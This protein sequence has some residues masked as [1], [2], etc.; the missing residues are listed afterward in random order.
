MVRILLFASLLFPFAGFGQSYELSSLN[1]DTKTSIRGLSIISDSVAWASGSNGHIGKTID[2]GQNW[3]WMQPLGY[4]KLDFRDIEAFDADRA[5]IVNAGSPAYILKTE[6]GGKSW[7]EVYKNIDSA[8]FLDGMDFWSEKRGIAFGDPIQNHLQLL[9]TNDGG[10][11]WTDIS[12]KL[13]FDM[14]KGEAGFAAS[15]TTIKALPG[16]RVWIATGGVKSNIYTSEDYG[17]NW[18]KFECPILQGSASTGVFGM[19]FYEGSYGSQGIVVGGDYTKDK[20]NSNNVLLTSDG[21]KTWN[22]PSKPVYG[23]RSGVLMYNDKN[24]IATGSSGTDISKD[25]G[26]TWYHI[27]DEG[28]NVVKRAK[29]GGLV[30]LAGDKG[31]IFSFA[32][33]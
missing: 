32:I 33:K 29:N 24:Y 27:S 4:E 25:G 21:G 31:Q 3:K 12:S 11:S 15:G 18:K 1:M 28:F 30:L 8:I 22:K 19:D 10:D 14:E 13:G 5:I 17:I 2:G 20:E 26:Q 6:D 7:K 16:G 9:I 23:Y